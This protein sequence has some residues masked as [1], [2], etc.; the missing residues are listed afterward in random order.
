[1]LSVIIPTINEGENLK[2][3][4]PE[5]KKYADEVIIVD[6]ESTDDTVEVALKYDCR[7]LRRKRGSG[8]ASAVYEG[9]KLAKYEYVAIMDADLSHSPSLLK[10]VYLLEE[11][12]A[13]IVKPSRFIAGGSMEYY[14]RY[15]LQKFYNQIIS[16]LAG[17]NVHDF[18]TGF[19]IAKKESFNFKGM[20]KWG[21]WNVEYMLRN[22]QRRFAEIPYPHRHR[23]FG[24]SKY[25]GF[26][27]IWRAF[28]YLFYLLVFKIKDKM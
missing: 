9:V 23:K 21:E 1:M 27:D 19:V 6:D 4:L 25:A 7:V 12:L 3:L 8:I 28:R 10:C 5:V 13:D 24:K 14:L 2:L 26:K 18:T 11:D 17:I 16:F 22:S 20:A 15:K